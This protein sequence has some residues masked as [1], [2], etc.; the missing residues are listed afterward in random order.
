MKDKDLLLNKIRKGDQLSRRER[1]SLIIALSIP[2]MLAELAGICQSYIDASMVG[3]IGAEASASIGL[4]SSSIWLFNGLTMAAMTGFT[5]QTAQRIGASQEEHAR[6]ILKQAFAIGMT[7]A[8]VMGGVG[9]AIS[10]RLPIWLGGNENI[11]ADATA[12]FAT[13]MA[14]L[15]MMMIRN[16]AGGFLRAS[17][18]VKTPSFVYMLVCASDV[19]FNFFLIFPTRVIGGITVPGAGL[20]VFGAALG[21]MLSDVVGSAILMIA[22][23]VRPNV[24]KP[25]KGEKLHFVA[26]DLKSWVRITLPVLGERVATNGA[27]IICTRIVAPLGTISIA[28]HSYGVTAE[29]LCY[30]PGFGISEAAG[31]LVGQSIGAKRKDLAYDLG[32]MN[33]I[34][35]MG[36][37]T[38]TGIL[39]YIFAPNIMGILSVD[40]GVI[41][42]GARVL[43]IEAFAEPLFAASIVCAGVLR[44]AGDTLMSGV[45]SL[46]SM[47]LVRVPLSAILAGSMGLN[48]VWLAMALE[49][50]IRG[51]M[52]LIRLRR[53]KWL[54]ASDKD[55]G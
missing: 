40:P 10:G 19:V 16:L 12:Y 8:F 11:T 36:V 6:N 29:S 55:L 28:A 44:G 52:F 45:I 53:K 24:L 49:L 41:E 32:R 17:G 39:M 48:G 9:L 46:C 26:D 43:R 37:M 25:V 15:P 54:N 14:A 22:L 21:T 33:T 18:N 7:L 3:R 50:S 20:A 42:L 13:L 35:G 4:M 1:L 30:C 47:W 31:M 38:L 23:F 27:Q 51:I 5:V 34:L 2:A